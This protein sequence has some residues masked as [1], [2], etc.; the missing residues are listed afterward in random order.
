MYNIS[1]D[2]FYSFWLPSGWFICDLDIKNWIA[3][4]SIRT[5]V[6]CRPSFYSPA[7]GYTQDLGNG[8]KVLLFKRKSW[9][10]DLS[11]CFSLR[12]FFESLY[13]IFH[14]LYLMK[15]KKSTRYKSC[16]KTCLM[17]EKFLMY[18]KDTYT[19]WHL[20]VYRLKSQHWKHLWIVFLLPIF[21]ISYTS[22][23]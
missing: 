15:I 21:F 12:V 7:I 3:F 6:A 9:R 22:L 23:P 18:I 4:G 19:V 17:F 10:R 2:V 20:Q 14:V 8:Q 1:T 13:L 11:F 5:Q 16:E